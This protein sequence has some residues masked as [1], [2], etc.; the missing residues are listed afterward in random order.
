MVDEVDGG[1]WMVTDVSNIY[2]S[3]D[4]VDGGGLLLLR[5]LLKCRC[6]NRTTH[7]KDADLQIDDARNVC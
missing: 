5:C 1:E 4:G 6:Q 2:T 3:S 7:N